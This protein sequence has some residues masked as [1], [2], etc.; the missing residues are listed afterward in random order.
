[1]EVW[2]AVVGVKGEMVVGLGMEEGAE[3]E[4]SNGFSAIYLLFAWKS[5]RIYFE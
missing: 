3:E 2:R 5:C 4:Q 1:M